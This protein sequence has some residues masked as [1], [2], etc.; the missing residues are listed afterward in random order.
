MKQYN[1]KKMILIV[2]VNLIFF[3]GT[4]FAECNTNFSNSWKN[5]RY[6][7]INDEIIVDVKT[8][9]TWKRCHE[10]LS[11]L[12]CEIGS[13]ISYNWQEALQVAADSTSSNYSDWRVPNVKELGSL[14]SH[15]CFYPSI[16]DVAFPNTSGYFWTSTPTYSDDADEQY[17]SYSMNF[18]YNATRPTTDR[19]TL[20]HVRLVR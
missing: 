4:A 13:P 18:D 20:L 12:N 16:N 6:N 14:L 15:G 9:L 7:H 1:I 10:G 17:Y 11:G 2:G 8:K 3:H 19:R 5:N